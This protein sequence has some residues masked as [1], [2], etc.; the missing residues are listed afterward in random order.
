MKM[1]T[2][3]C[4]PLEVN[5]RIIQT[6]TNYAPNDVERYYMTLGNLKI[7]RGGGKMWKNFHK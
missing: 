5:P 3:A 1:N 6:S 2:G 7:T 4:V